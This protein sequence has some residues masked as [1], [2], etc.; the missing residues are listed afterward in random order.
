MRITNQN[1]LEERKHKENKYLMSFGSFD[2][3]KDYEWNKELM[4]PTKYSLGQ[5]QD[6]ENG[7]N[8]GRG[9]QETI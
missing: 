1:Q 4:C 5:S 6:W 9:A 7:K 2:L 3:V 8:C